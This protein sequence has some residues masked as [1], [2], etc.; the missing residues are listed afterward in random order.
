M[1]NDCDIKDKDKRGKVIAA[2]PS[3]LYSNGVI[4]EYYFTYFEG[5]NRYTYSGT[6]I[7]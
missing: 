4:F 5:R 1:A 7:I 3:I 2:A 6:S